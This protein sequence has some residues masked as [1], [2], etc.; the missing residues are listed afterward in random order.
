MTSRRPP[1]EA[2]R[3]GRGFCGPLPGAAL[4]Y[5]EIGTMWGANSG[6]TVLHPEE[7][8]QSN[9]VSKCGPQA[10]RPRPILRDAFSISV[11]TKRLL[12]MK[13]FA[14]CI[15]HTPYH[16]PGDKPVDTYRPKAGFSEG[17]TVI[18][19]SP[20]TT[21]LIGATL[22][23][24][25][26]SSLLRGALQPEAGSGSPP[27]SVFQDAPSHGSWWRAAPGSPSRRGRAAS[28]PW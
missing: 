25:R 16:T 5:A 13:F 6:S 2:G 11:E 7:A 28:A 17:F 4:F 10:L 1:K 19:V 23:R 3:H 27:A 18:G 24:R 9:A 12:R 26:R 22:K 8:W 14:G 21:R 20:R 15:S